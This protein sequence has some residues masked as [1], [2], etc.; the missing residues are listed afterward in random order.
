[1]ELS[2]K[3]DELLERMDRIENLLTPPKVPE[4]VE[5]EIYFE[6]YKNC[7]KILG[8]TKPHKD[9]IKENGGKWNS[10][11]KCWI[12]GKKSL[13]GM[14]EVLSGIESLNIVEK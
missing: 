5:N 8:D 12:I 10:G 9:A 13:E 14:K 2:K 1:M 3:L 7:Y 6:S 11:L 4:I